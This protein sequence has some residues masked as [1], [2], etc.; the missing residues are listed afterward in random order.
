MSKTEARI[1]ISK[2]GPYFVSGDVPLSKQSIV[3]DDAAGSQAWQESAPFESLANYALCRCGYSMSSPFCDG[4]HARIGFDGTESASREP[5][6]KE[7]RV[8]D[9]PM[10]ALMDLESLCSFARF[11]DPN[12]QVW[13]Q[14]SQSDDRTAQENFLRQVGNCPGGRLVAWDNQTKKPIEPELPVSI[15]LIEDPAQACSGPIWLRGGIPVVSA[16][17]FEYEVRNRVTLCRCGQSQNKPFCDG[18]HVRVKFRGTYS[19][20][21]NRQIE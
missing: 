10:M 16:D 21:E 19:P 11:C 15:G 13:N 8:I 3:T 4:A 14:V 7:A 12:G 1:V 6:F 17:G 2:D 5:Y 9:G 20:D 18:A